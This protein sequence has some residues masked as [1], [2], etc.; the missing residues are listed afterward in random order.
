MPEN[1]SEDSGRSK[2]TLTRQL[3]KV[4]SMA[5]KRLI[6]SRKGFDSTRRPRGPKRGYAGLEWPYGGVPSPVFPDG[7]MYSLPVP[8]EDESITVTY[9]DLSHRVGGA[10]VNIGKVV[11][12][13][14][15]TRGQP[16]R[17]TRD[18][19][20]YVSPDIRDP[21][22]STLDEQPG[23]VGAGGAQ[24]GHLR[25]QGVDKDD[26]F[27]FFGLFRRVEEVSGRWQ[28]VPRAPEQH[29]L[30][31]WLQ[32]GAIHREDGEGWQGG[33]YVAGDALLIPG[34]TTTRRGYGV[35]DR[36]DERL[37]L[38][39]P[40]ADPSRWRLP[41][42]FYPEPPRAPLT[43]HPRPLWHRDERYA[44][45]QRRGPGQEFVLDLRH[46]PEALDWVSRIVGDLGRKP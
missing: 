32:V 15:S 19:F 16:P 31:G 11:E 30:F 20:T 7:S 45:V 46:Y 34:H 25:K 33:W 27:L 8:G 14:T 36:L 24:E 39:E 1:G 10:E 37:V 18:D 17:W 5:A 13:L 44:Y 4:I 3:P 41:H 21:V 9:G 23:L 26:I 28:F 42:W 40:S 22:W 29:V 35:F 38:S 12:D 6:I 43:Y 2:P